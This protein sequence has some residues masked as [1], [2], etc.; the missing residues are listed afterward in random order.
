[1][2]NAFA[3]YPSLAGKTVFITGGASGIG[4]EIVRGFSDA[5][6]GFIDL[7]LLVLPKI[8]AP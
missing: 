8:Y 6:V 1:M 7:Q 2:T 5:E 4:A 3:N